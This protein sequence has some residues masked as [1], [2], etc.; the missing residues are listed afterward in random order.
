MALTGCLTFQRSDTS[1]CL[2]KNESRTNYAHISILNVQLPIAFVNASPNVLTEDQSHVSFFCL[3]V[4]ENYEKS[5]IE[6]KVRPTLWLYIQACFLS[7][8]LPHG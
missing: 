4:Y 8:R 6:F 1:S 2:S 7:N 3:K 5:I